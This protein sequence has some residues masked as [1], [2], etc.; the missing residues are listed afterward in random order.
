MQRTLDQNT[1]LHALIGQLRL[2]ADMKADLVSQFSAGRCTSS[3]D[4]TVME[5]AGLISYLEGIISSP[6]KQKES[7]RKKMVWR[8]YFMLRDR[9]YFP[10]QDAM[11]AMESLDRMTTKVWH[12]SAT[13]MTSK[14]LSTYIGI[15]RNWKYKKACQEY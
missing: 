11:E 13:T 2:D 7:V 4:L 6:E 5:C 15:V 1:K 14:E 10:H 8:L 12:K 9:G 3:R